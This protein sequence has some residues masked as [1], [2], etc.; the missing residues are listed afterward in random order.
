MENAGVSSTNFEDQYPLALDHLDHKP[1]QHEPLKKKKSFW[2]RNKKETIVEEDES[3]VEVSREGTTSSAYDAARA[4]M[5]DSLTAGEKEEMRRHLPLLR[6]GGTFVKH[7]RSGKPK[8]KHVFVN[9]KGYFFWS[10]TSEKTGT[11]AS[12]NLQEAIQVNAGKNTD[13]FA[14]KNAQ[15]APSEHCFSII[16]KG[17]T[18]DLQADNVDTRDIWVEALRYAISHTHLLGSVDVRDGVSGTSLKEKALERRAAELEGLLEET[19]RSLHMK[20]VALQ[21]REKQLLEERKDTKKELIVKEQDLIEAREELRMLKEN[22]TTLSQQIKKVHHD[23]HAS[24]N[25]RQ[26]SLK[27]LQEKI[28]ELEKKNRQLEAQ[29]AQEKATLTEVVDNSKTLLEKAKTSL[30]QRGVSRT[31]RLAVVEALER[32]RDELRQK[33]QELREELAKERQ[34]KERALKEVER[35]RNGL[36]TIDVSNLSVSVPEEKTVD[37]RYLGSPRIPFNEVMT[38]SVWQ[39]DHESKNCTSCEKEFSFFKRR[40]HCRKW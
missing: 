35:V 17:R 40:H 8:E 23:R 1:Q 36:D 18:V 11:F 37:R 29:H 26:S 3:S 16:V 38:P 13:V 20:T 10:N 19:K 14:R 21:K 15:S 2:N 12:V 5:L 25:L 9:D 7:G 24:R 39:P 32:E 6:A 4:S 28:R 31:K 34:E 27:G 30:H 33:C 22:E